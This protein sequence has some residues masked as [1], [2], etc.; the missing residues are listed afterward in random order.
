MRS[1]KNSSNL[2]TENS[3]HNLQILLLFYVSKYV[4]MWASHS[5]AINQALH[6]KL[7][8]YHKYINNYKHR[9][10]YK[11]LL[12]NYWCSLVNK[13]RT[14]PRSG[15]QIF[16]YLQQ[17]T[18][19]PHQ[20]LT[21]VDWSFQHSEPWFFNNCMFHYLPNHYALLNVYRCFCGCGTDSIN[22]LRSR[23]CCVCTKTRWNQWTKMFL[24]TIPVLLAQTG[25]WCKLTLVE[26][27][28]KMLEM[29]PSNYRLLLNMTYY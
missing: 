27:I 12:S 14:P 21:A 10:F 16:R 4:F 13:A 24:L 15:I 9:H 25:L 1:F 17:E 7:D 29:C 6:Q 23:N 28:L 2:F 19:Y 5:A 3:Q 11:Q 18:I 26:D 8:A 22:A 20:S